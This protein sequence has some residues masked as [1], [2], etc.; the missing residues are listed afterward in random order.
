MD[1][2]LTT[3]DDYLL[4][5]TMDGTITVFFALRKRSTGRVWKLF[6]ADWKLEPH[7][8][9]CALRIYNAADEPVDEPIRI[10]TCVK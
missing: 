7:Q 3:A 9:A 10:N 1:R 5:K 8:D 6:P 2:G 4:F